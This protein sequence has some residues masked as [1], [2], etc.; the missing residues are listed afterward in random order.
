MGLSGKIEWIKIRMMSKV[1]YQDYL[2][3]KG[4]KIGNG[5]DI[6]KTASFGS[7]PYL[8]SIGNHVRIN[9]GVLFIT[10]DGGYWILRNQLAGFGEKFLNADRFG[11]IEIGDNVHIGNNAIIMPGVK[12][13]E[14]SVVACGAVV[15]HDIE[16]RSIVGGVPARVIESLDE[17][18]QKAEKRMIN[19]KNLSPEERELMIRKQYL[20]E[21]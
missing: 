8:I 7:E 4:M 13:G 20:K 3:G 10:H 16:P 2:R 17:Y 11:T 1:K 18:A 6:Y 21:R 14:N 19:T 9:E 12:I 15:T 5:C